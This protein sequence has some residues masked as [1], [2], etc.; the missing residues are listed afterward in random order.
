M[1]NNN[2][3][4]DQ[5]AL[6][7]ISALYQSSN[8]FA[9]PTSGDNTTVR[10]PPLQSCFVRRQITLHQTSPNQNISE[11]QSVVDRVPMLAPEMTLMYVPL[12]LK[13]DTITHYSSSN[14]VIE[15]PKKNWSS[16]KDEFIESKYHRTKSRSSLEMIQSASLCDE[17]YTTSS[18]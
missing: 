6:N 4:D 16:T 3:N 15:E 14:S 2:S 9:Q 12:S 8:P 18:R 7:P 10:N 5:N 11:L 17:Q 13:Y 1:Q